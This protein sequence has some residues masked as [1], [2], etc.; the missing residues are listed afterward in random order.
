MRD[1]KRRGFTYHG[2]DVKA[3][4]A[5]KAT[6]VHISSCGCN[7]VPLLLHIHSTK[8]GK[9][10]FLAACFYFYKDN[11]AIVVGNDVDL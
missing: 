7:K 8:S 4:R 10:T 6:Q 3:E 5:V 1:L 11:L 9:K 2:N